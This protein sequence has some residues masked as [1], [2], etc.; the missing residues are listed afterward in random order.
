MGGKNR[1]P[2]TQSALLLIGMNNRI[3]AFA[4]PLFS[5]DTYIHHRRR[6]KRGMKRRLK[7]RMKRGY[8]FN[9]ANKWVC[10]LTAFHL[11]Q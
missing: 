11:L 1:Y 8:I 9:V 4:R 10:V 5:D 7:K 2:E 3:G 6:L